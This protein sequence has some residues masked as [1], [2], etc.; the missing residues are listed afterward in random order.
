MVAKTTVLETD[1]RKITTA[2]NQQEWLI[3][4]KEPGTGKTKK[5]PKF[6]IVNR[7][8]AAHLYEYL[9]SFHVPNI[10]VSNQE[11]NRYKAMP[12]EIIPIRVLVHNIARDH[13]VNDFGVEEGAELESP[14]LE[15][16]RNSGNGNEIMINEYHAMAF[17]LSSAEE[18][19]M[20]G[21]MATKI[22]AILK[23]YFMRRDLRLVSFF[24]EFGKRDGHITLSSELD[25]H[26]CRFLDP[27]VKREK[28]PFYTNGAVPEKAY[29]DLKKRLFEN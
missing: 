14:V 19:R 10:Y 1:Y 17:S 8:I 11:N 25:L 27:N 5:K 7:D 4:L 2:D 3:E 9:N 20:M 23:S 12:V 13:L 18:F 24:C 15:F 26:S 29:N 22:N 21:R 28:D 6:S 16:Y